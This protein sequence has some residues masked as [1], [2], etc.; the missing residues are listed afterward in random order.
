MLASEIVYNVKNLV[1]GG[2]QSDD[3][4]LSNK[5]LL[6]IVDYYRAKLLRQDQ[7][8]G[9]FNSDLWTQNLG[10][11]S[12]IKADKNEC[13]NIDSCVLRTSLKVPSPLETHQR[14]NIT[15]V[16]TVG[17]LPFQRFALNAIN[18]KPFDKWTGKE[19]A[20]YY[21]NGYIYI[22][23]PPTD[24][25]SY[26]NIQGIFERPDE[27]VRFRTCDCNLNEE[28]CFETLDF[29]YPF[30]QHYV[31]TLVKLIYQTELKLLLTLAPDTDNNGQS[32]VSDAH[33][34]PNQAQ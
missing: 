8:R 33:P 25:L 34:Q 30:P 28:K 7:D 4:D 32:Q 13:C 5:Q 3:Q 11:V 22:V 2:I 26:I 18:W 6:F 14:I 31:D 17:G 23:N 16:G 12:L 15:F 1:A 27:A 29:E 19:P 21:Q 24:M 9:R 20:W 10:K